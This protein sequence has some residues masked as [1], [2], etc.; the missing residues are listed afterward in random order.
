MTQRMRTIGA[1]VA[2]IVLGIA[3]WYLREHVEG[4]GRG[5]ILVLLGGA[6]VAGYFHSKRY[7]LLVVGCL[8]L[9][10]GL[11]SVG[12]RTYFSADRS[13]AVPLGLGFIA[14]YVIQL[15]W[16]RRARWWPLIPGGL[17]VILGLD[18]MRRWVRLAVENWPLLLVV[19]GVL[20][21]LGALFRGNR[22]PPAGT[23]TSR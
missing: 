18:S 10:L 19:A 23:D 12:E 22:E 17:L 15:A 16:E 14:I 9:S 6:S 2:L 8:L 11:G 4:L 20:V 21:V 3:V 7:G 5:W 1:G 13:N